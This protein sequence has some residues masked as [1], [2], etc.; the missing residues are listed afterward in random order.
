MVH[1]DQILQLV[2]A[3]N[4]A[5]ETMVSRPLA[6]TTRIEGDARRPPSN[7]VGIITDVPPRAV[8]V[9]DGQGIRSS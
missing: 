7:L 6:T 2:Q 5:F 1:S 9:P 8:P 3:M 4:G